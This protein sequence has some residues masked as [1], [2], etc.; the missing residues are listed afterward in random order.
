LR[1]QNGTFT[2]PLAARTERQWIWEARVL[3]AIAGVGIWECD[4]PIL[5]LFD[6]VFADIGTAARSAFMP[7][8]ILITIGKSRL[9]NE[10]MFNFFISWQFAE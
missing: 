9:V 8:G 6:L 2:T 5:R 4:W 1:N 3:A 10:V 7:L